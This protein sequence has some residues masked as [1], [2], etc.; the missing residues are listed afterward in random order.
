MNETQ[1]KTLNEIISVFKHYLTTEKIDE[2]NIN[3]ELTLLEELLKSD[4]KLAALPAEKFK[5]SAAKF[6][7][8]VYTFQDKKCYLFIQK[9][10]KVTLQLDYKERNKRYLADNP[11]CLFLQARLVY[12][13]EIDNKQFKHVHKDGVDYVE[14]TTSTKQVGN[15]VLA[16]AW[17]RFNRG[18]ILYNIYEFTK[19]SDL[20]TRLGMSTIGGRASAQKDDFYKKYAFANLF[21][22]L[23]NYEEETTDVSEI[24]AENTT[25]APALPEIEP[26][27]EELS[28]FETLLNDP[29]KLLQ[30]IRS[31]VYYFAQFAKGNAEVFAEVPE[32]EHTAKIIHAVVAANEMKLDEISRL[33][34]LGSKTKSE[35]EALKNNTELRQKYGWAFDLRHEFFA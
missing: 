30:E 15:P 13:N 29:E 5:A 17:A 4:E 19:A 7:K 23:G 9:G 12:Q 8:N 14:H 22:L 3:F 26:E 35:V 2:S 20:S 21:K 32:S 6:A 28:V 31:D 11:D 18:G 34:T 16:Y 1:K 27:P 10:G 25:D 24:E 33:S